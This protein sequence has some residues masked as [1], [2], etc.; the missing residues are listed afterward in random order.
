MSL[1]GSGRSLGGSRFPGLRV[2]GGSAKEGP[3]RVWEESGRLWEESGRSLGGV[4]EES[5][6]EHGRSMEEL[7]VRI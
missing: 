2:A 3:T 6:W 5:G 7:G 1:G 4:W